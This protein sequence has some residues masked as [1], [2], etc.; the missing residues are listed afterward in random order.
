MKK[1]QDTKGNVTGKEKDRDKILYFYAMKKP[2]KRKYLNS[3]T[4][5]YI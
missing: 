3:N 4:S 2:Y 1:N 5:Y